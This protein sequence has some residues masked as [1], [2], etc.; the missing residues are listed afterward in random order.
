MAR[1]SW[2]EA[3]AALMAMIVFGSTS[4]WAAPPTVTSWDPAAFRDLST[5]EFRTV[6]PDEGE[7]WSTVWLVVIDD[8]VYLRLGAKA[9]DRMRRNKTAPIVAVRV[10]GRT[11]ERVRAEEAAAMAPRVG[12]AMGDKY[13]TDLLIRYAAHPLTMRLQPEPAADGQ[14]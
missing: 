3:I 10:G 7:H 13:W 2:C 5:L 6:G 1:N 14:P 12:A 9:A 11:Y 8:Q 4:A